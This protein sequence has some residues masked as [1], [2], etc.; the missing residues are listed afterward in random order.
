MKTNV[1]IVIGACVVFFCGVFLLATVIF[2]SMKGSISAAVSSV[3]C[4]PGMY[5]VATE[6]LG[7]STRLVPYWIGFA[8][9][10][11]ES[12]DDLNMFSGRLDTIEKWAAVL[13]DA[14]E[15]ETYLQVVK[16]GREDLAG[17][18]DDLGLRSSMTKPPPF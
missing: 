8:G 1:A 3:N 10:R 17:Y 16:D 2:I 4:P 14:C 13:D 7:A 18:Q 5:G 9:G 15:R 12:E 6:N 11:N